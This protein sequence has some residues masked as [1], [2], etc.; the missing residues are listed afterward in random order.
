MFVGYSD[1]TFLHLFL[2]RQG[3]VTVHGPMVARELAD[4][5]YDAPSFW[6]AVRTRGEKEISAIYS[7]RRG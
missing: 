2:H 4:G 1:V 6:S 7:K 5:G 3:L